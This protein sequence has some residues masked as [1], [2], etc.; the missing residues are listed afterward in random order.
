MSR[1]QYTDREM[2]E[3]LIR[4][5]SEEPF[6]KELAKFMSCAPTASAIKRQADKYPDRW[7][8]AMTM[9]RKAA[10]YAEKTEHTYN[11]NIFMRLQTASDSELK[12]LEEQT[13]AELQAVVSGQSSELPELPALEGEV[14]DRTDRKPTK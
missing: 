9:L 8:Q 4:T 1:T 12:V 3:N 5:Q 6:Q 11:T 14:L 7:V 13:K 10:G 2:I